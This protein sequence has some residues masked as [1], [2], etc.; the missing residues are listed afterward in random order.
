MKKVILMGLLIAL[1]V[2]TQ[3]Q[4]TVETAVKP[5]I[6][7]S[8]RWVVKT[9]AL[10]AILSNPRKG[11][12]FYTL[13]GEYCFRGKNSVQL[14]IM[15]Y[16]DKQSYSYPNDMK[17]GQQTKELQLMPMYKRFFGK[18][19]AYSG[20]YMGLGGFVSKGNNTRLSINTP[21]NYYYKYRYTGVG[22]SLNIGYQ[23]YIKDH[24]VIDGMIGLGG[25]TKFNTLIG[26]NYEKAYKS[27]NSSDLLAN[28]MLN[29]GYR[30]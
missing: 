17:G 8:P 3:A 14:T 11:D 21:L 25:F 18:K 5:T 10:R 29:L 19:H 2:L 1:S 15:P 24:I 4:K 20:V 30:F 6:D 7:P 26:S 27:Y 9:D 16:L 12:F 23:R 22:G 28:F 13:A